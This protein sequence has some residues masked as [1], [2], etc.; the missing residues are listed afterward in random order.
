MKSYLLTISILLNL[1]LAAVFG[2]TIYQNNRYVPPTDSQVA[3][4][5]RNSNTF[6]FKSE[7]HLTDKAVSEL[8]TTVNNLKIHAWIPTWAID[9]SIRTLEQKKNMFASVSPVYYSLSDKGDTNSGIKK[10][11]K[12]REVLKDSNVKIIPTV[13]GFSADGLKVMLSTDENI[14][15]HVNFLMKEVDE[16]GY[17]GI[18]LDYESIYLD[19]KDKFFKLLSN[20][21]S[22]LHKRNKILTIAVI[23]KWGDRIT[24][25][26]LPQTRQVQ[27]YAEIAKYVDQVRIMTY[28][29][30]SINSQTP[31]PIAPIEWMDQVLDYAVKRIPKEKIVLGVN[32]YSYVWAEG[33]K[34]R[35]LDYRMISNLQ[36]INDTTTIFYSEKYE[37]GVVRYTGNENKVN[38]GYFAS[39]ESVKARLE[40]AAKYG[41]GGVAF[42]RLGDDP[43]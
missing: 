42:W 6:K 31:G 39:P 14:A 22:E 3:T 40:L 24:Y 37:E 15:T 10:L 34:G 27:D 20:F 17:D 5:L 29:Y 41:I 38:F 25:G 32:L 28:D 2:Y 8:S 43:L 11:D 4:F 19:D 7:T 18:D 26:S 21:S 23:S 13:S 9:A 35:G 33:E 16:K 36:V 12:L 30:T 1:I